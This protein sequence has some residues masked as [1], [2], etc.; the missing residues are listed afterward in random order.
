MF[1]RRL[2]RMTRLSAKLT[3]AYVALFV[4]VLTGILGAVYVSLAGNTEKVVRDELNASAVVFDRVWRMRAEQLG[5]SSGLV[6]EDFGFKAAIASRDL[7]TIGSAVANLRRRLG[8]DLAVVIGADGKALAIDGLAPTPDK[9]AAVERLGQEDS[10]GGVAVL[11]ARPYEIVST[12]ILAPSPAGRL[13]FG[14]RLDQAE[15]SRLASLSP[16][17]LQPKIL[18]Q[19]PGGA[20]RGASDVSRAELAHA[21]AVLGEAPSTQG[22]PPPAVRVGPWIEVVRPLPPFGADRTALVLRYPISAALAVWNGLLATMLL[23]GLTGLALAAF[24]GWAVARE[25][26]RPIAALTAAAERLERGESGA[27]AVAGRDEIARLGQ[28]FNRMAEGILRRERALDSAR[29]VAESANQAKSDFLANMSHEIRTPLNG[30]LG[31]AQALGF[32]QLTPEQA[33]QLAVIKESGEG[34]LG[35]LNSIL[36]LSKIEAGRLEIETHDFD[37]AE[38][39]E[40]ACAPLAGLAHRKG[41]A[42]GI[43][44][45]AAAE[46]AWRG[47]PLRI[48][49]LIAN[50]ASNGVKFTESGSVAVRVRYGPGGLVLEVEDTG[51]GIQPDRLEAVFQKFTQGDASTTRRFGGSGLGLAI[52]RELA[53]LMGGELSVESV[54]GRGSKFTCVLPLARPTA[55]AASRDAGAQDRPLRILAAEDNPA[56][57]LILKALLEVTDS[58]VTIVAD[59]AQ[60]VDAFRASPFDIVLMD[61]Q[62]PVMGGVEATR[63]IRGLQSE[64][65]QPPTPILAVTANIMTHQVGEYLEAGMDGV[66]AKPLQIEILLREIERVLAGEASG[67]LL[68]S[69]VA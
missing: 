13:M 30:I 3:T 36:D 57:Q 34:L 33:A 2:A 9:A 16:I 68:A 27:V 17:A 12:P 64:L 7:P 23:L 22:K 29:V 8:V 18:V 60:A 32:H 20:W 67:P 51:I 43:D 28:T 59:G 41:L 50:L 54:V 52:C 55:P 11:S 38:V 66:V 24:G 6:S 47:D 65:G 37:L 48:R 21:A 49:Q 56:N 69:S 61:I 62:M 58:D 63:A 10:D 42:F 46:G 40:A 26:T 35:V 14:S 15:L 45:D 53:H 31:M 19:T 25:I 4:I 1:E 5:E 39:V 44:V